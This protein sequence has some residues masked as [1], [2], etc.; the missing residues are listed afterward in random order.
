MSADACTFSPP[1]ALRIQPRDGAAKEGTAD[2]SQGKGVSGR[3]QNH[4]SGDLASIISAQAVLMDGIVGPFGVVACASRPFFALSTPFAERA[5]DPSVPRPGAYALWKLLGPT[6]ILSMAL[7]VLQLPVPAKLA[8]ISLGVQRALSKATDDRV[9][10]IVEA[11]SALRVT[12]AFGASGL[13]SLHF[14][15]CGPLTCARRP[16]RRPREQRQA[17]GPGAAH[18]GDGD[19]PAQEDPQPRPEHHLADAAPRHAAHLARRL[20]RRP[21]GPA[22]APAAPQTSL[23]TQS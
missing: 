14:L 8:S 22:G 11:I 4:I 10:R 19:Q 15:R 3:L 12:K 21:E 20:R 13:P 1:A 9:Q 23:F 6:S 17:A 2:K 18:Q 16:A 5:A 7:M